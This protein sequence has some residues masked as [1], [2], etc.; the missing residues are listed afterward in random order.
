MIP[1]LH[2]EGG[3]HHPN[4]YASADQRCSPVNLH[5]STVSASRPGHVFTAMDVFRR[6]LDLPHAFQF[7]TSEFTLGR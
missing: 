3:D 5:V 2:A 1:P 7:S 6:L 4:Q